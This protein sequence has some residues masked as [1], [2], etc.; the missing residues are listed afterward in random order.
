MSETQRLRELVLKTA[1]R[2]VAFTTEEV[3]DL[4][5]AAGIF[6]RYDPK[7]TR[8][9][10]RRAVQRTISH[11]RDAAELRLFFADVADDGRQ[12]YLPRAEFLSP[13]ERRTRKLASVAQAFITACRNLEVEA[14]D[15][16]IHDALLAALA[17]VAPAD[18][19]EAAAA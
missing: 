8:D 18:D 11:L 10:H 1:R 2:N 12:V 14:E 17:H 6:R 13:G 3:L 15:G 9:A 19:A 4:A 7:R 16:L 5:Y